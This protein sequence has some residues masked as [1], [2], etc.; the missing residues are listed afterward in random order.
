MRHSGKAV[1]DARHEQSSEAAPT[2]TAS[3]GDQ[4]AVM[5][6]LTLACFCDADGVIY[7]LV[8]GLDEPVLD[9]LFRTGHLRGI[10]IDTLVRHSFRQLI[11]EKADER[12]ELLSALKIREDAL[13][14]VET[15]ENQTAGETQLGGL[16]TRH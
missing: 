6:Q 3:E 12:V 16:S 4:L 11:N 14:A 13:F 2:Q 15:F 5:R 1:E 9:Q 10:A 8:E 7:P